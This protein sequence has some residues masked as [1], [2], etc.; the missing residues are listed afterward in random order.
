LY[1]PVGAKHLAAVRR[2]RGTPGL[3]AQVGLHEARAAVTHAD[4]DAAGVRRLGHARL[5]LLQPR[6]HLEEHRAVHAV[7]RRADAVAGVAPAGR[8]ALAHL[9]ALGE[10]DGVRR[11]VRDGRRKSMIA[12]EAIFGL[13]IAD[14]GC[15]SRRAG[16]RTARSAGCP[17]LHTVFGSW[18]AEDL[19]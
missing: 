9:V 12:L 1:L 2:G 7:T 5:A 10:K 4:V 3:P 11:A 15:S 13:R 18:V 14:N 6:R 17:T 19:E 16:W 8:L